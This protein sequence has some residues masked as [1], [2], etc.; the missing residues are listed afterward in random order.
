MILQLRD[1]MHFRD[2]IN[3]AKKKQAR[4]LIASMLCLIS[5]LQGCAVS[6]YAPEQKIPPKQ[7]QNDVAV[8][9]KTLQ[10]NHPGL[11]WYATKASIDSAFK[12]LEE[13]A[14][15]SLT[16]LSFHNNIARMLAT[17]ECG[18]TAVRFSKQYVKYLI[19]SRYPMFPLYLYNWE[20][21][22]YVLKNMHSNDTN[23]IRGLEVSAINHIS[24]QQIIDSLYQY[25]SADANNH[26]FKAQVMSNN[27]PAWYKMI[28]GLDTMYQIQYI[29]TLGIQRE[30]SI[31]NYSPKEDTVHQQ[32]K[33]SKAYPLP[34]K[35]ISALEQK[36]SLRIDSLHRFAYM[37]VSS[38]SGGRLRGFFRRSFRDL[39]KMKI[40]NL[41]IDVR[42]NGG[43][44]VNKS[45]LLT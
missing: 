10:Q 32:A 26:W 45:V 27:F 8:L 29:D 30:T 11:Y 33:I 35:R 20:N 39:H 9:Q 19:E 43:G 17:I 42:G 23:L 5:L 25:I 28:F 37:H 21:H 2:N 4:R 40:P 12:A 41:I 16:E 1:G 34:S 18:H 31:K 6:K 3:I 15:D 14:K 38:F 44:N 24:A 7:L 13:S 36:R 22:L